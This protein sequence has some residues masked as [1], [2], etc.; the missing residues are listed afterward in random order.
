MAGDRPKHCSWHVVLG[1][2]SLSDEDTLSAQLG[3]LLGGSVYN[4]TGINLASDA[5]LTALLDRL[6]M[7]RGTVIYEYAD[8][9][10]VPTASC[11]GPSR[12]ADA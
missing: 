6:G 4:A 3:A 2:A 10:R 11:C 7:R 5:Q 1:G 12:P 9:W 8:S